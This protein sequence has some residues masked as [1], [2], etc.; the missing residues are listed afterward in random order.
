[1]DATSEHPMPRPSSRTVTLLSACR[2]TVM[3]V[4]KPAMASSMELS[5]TSYTRWC[6]PRTSVEPMYMA[7]RLRT[8]DNP[9]RMVMD[10]AS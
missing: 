3:R 7:G 6:R 8:A 5:T 9:S 10:E 2:M 4:Q 1:M